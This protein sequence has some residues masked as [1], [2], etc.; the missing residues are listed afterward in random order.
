MSLTDELIPFTEADHFRGM[1]LANFR[2]DSDEPLL[3]H[4]AWLEKYFV[5]V[6]MKN[7]GAR[8]H[9]IGMASRNGNADY[10]MKLSARRINKVEQIIQGAAFIQSKGHVNVVE[11]NPRGEAQAEED[12]FRDGDRSG[13]Y[14]AVLLRWE[15]LTGPAPAPG[16][17]PNKFKKVLIKTQPGVWLITGVDTF[18]VSIDFVSAGKIAVTL[19]NDKGEQWVIS[20]AGVGAGHGGSSTPNSVELDKTKAKE[21][22]EIVKESAKGV[23]LKLGDLPNLA[24]KLQDALK[25]MPPTSATAGGVFRGTNIVSNFKIGEI[26]ASKMMRVVSVSQG[27]GV[28]AGEGGV[29]LFSDLFNSNLTAPWGAYTGLSTLKAGVEIGAMFY[30][31]TDVKMK[32]ILEK[33]VLDLS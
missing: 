11:K 15:G 3:S 18:G 24:D 10:N 16:P 33:E 6:M 13:R 21:I 22:L 28:V 23:L 8:V 2:N 20:G 26:T 12:G 31:I 30:R 32:G 7:P 5:P 4:K 9:M 17:S 27:V 14:R 19:L 1:R 29:I 25:D